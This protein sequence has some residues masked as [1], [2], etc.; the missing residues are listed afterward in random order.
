MSVLSSML[1]SQRSS[2]MGIL[3]LTFFLLMF[4]SLYLD[5]PSRVSVL[6][7]LYLVS[8]NK[9]SELLITKKKK[10]RFDLKF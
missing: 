7:L 3:F 4:Q 8:I 10:K 5:L 2:M 9:G 6:L 1:M